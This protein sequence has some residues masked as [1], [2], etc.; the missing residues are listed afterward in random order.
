M[1]TIFTPAF[2]RANLLQKLYNSLLEQTSHNFEWLVVDDGSEDNTKEIVESWSRT[3]AFFSIRYFQQPNGGKHRAIN[4]GVREAKGDVFF[5]V[6]SDDFLLPHAIEEVERHYRQIEAEKSIAGVVFTRI[7]PNG[8]RIGGDISF[9]PL[10][11]TITDFRCNRHIQG[12]LAETVR[13][14]VMKKYPFPEVDGE[15]FCPEAFLWYQIDQDHDFLFVNKGIYVGEYLPDGLSAKIKK[16]LRESPVSA[17]MAYAAMVR[18][19]KPFLFKAKNTISY[20][21]YYCHSWKKYHP[22]KLP[23]RA[24]SLFMFPLGLLLFIKDL[25]RVSV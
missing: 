17:T 20:W 16:I 19:R 23:K 6:D 15:K 13:L 9:Q 8:C 14:S 4:R 22:E 25:M 5:I 18:G 3:T 10:V 7:Y 24:L 2:N 12:D 11:T 21:R 1:I